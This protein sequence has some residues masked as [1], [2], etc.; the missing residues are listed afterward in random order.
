MNLAVFVALCV[1]T[2]IALQAT[3]VGDATNVSHPLAVSLALLVSG[4][5]V[6]SAWATVHG[7]WPDVVAVAGHWWWLPLGVV[8]WGIV[9]ALGWTVARIGVPAALAVVV[10]SQ[11]TVALVIDLAR[12]VTTAGW[13]S[14][15][16]V[17]F[18]MVGTTLLTTSR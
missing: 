7:A 15:A 11:L 4:L 16:G 17:A 5:I 3:A 1:G 6:A 2:A 10:G 14:V 18:V 13:R 8:G 12:G 9:A